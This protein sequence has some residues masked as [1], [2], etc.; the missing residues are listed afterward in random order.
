[1]RRFFR[2]W[3]GQAGSLENVAERACRR[4]FHAWYPASPVVPLIS[5]L[6]RMGACS[7]RRR[8]AFS[9]ASGVA[10]EHPFGLLLQVQK[11]LRTDFLIS[12]D[13]SIARLPRHSELAAELRDRY[14]LLLVAR[15]ELQALIHDST[16]FP[17]H[18]ASSCVRPKLRNHQVPLRCNACPLVCFVTQVLSTLSFRHPGKKCRVPHSSCASA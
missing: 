9:I 4:P 18:T 13:P 11:A 10:W 5:V 15:Q 1:M 17:G 3:T 12:V 6:P 7:V 14:L 2:L 8:I 16:L